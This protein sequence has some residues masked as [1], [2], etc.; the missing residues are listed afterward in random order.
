MSFANPQLW[1]NGVWFTLHLLAITST[2]QK[3]TIKTIKLILHSLPCEMCRTHA[4]EYLSRYPIED[5]IG[6]KMHNVDKL[7]LFVW[8]F[9]FHNA[10]NYRLGKQTMEWDVAYNLYSPF[11]K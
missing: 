3:E 10:V 9:K 6:V 11:K 4:L 5:Y 8:T 7:G 2:N 1:G